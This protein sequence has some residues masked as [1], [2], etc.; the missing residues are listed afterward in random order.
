MKNIATALTCLAM[1]GSASAAS[2]AI[3]FAENTNQAFV[4]GTALGPTGIDGSNWNSS[5]DRD[6]GDFNAGSITNL[7]DD[8]GALTGASVTWNSQNTWVA[9]GGTGSDDAKL[10]TG[11]LDDA[12]TI[13]FDNTT[14]GAV[15][16]DITVSGITFD[17]YTIYGILASDAGDQY[18][19]RNFQVNG[20]YVWGGSN[21]NAQAEAYGNSTAAFNATGS[22]WVEIEQGVT[23]GNYWT[24]DATGS[25]V[26]VN[27][28]DAWDGGRGSLA[29]IVI[30]DTTAVP[31]P[32]S[33]ALLG[34]GGL[35]MI[36]RRRK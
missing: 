31:E 18:S 22:Y 5:I 19:S 3:N 8:S 35:A 2:I 14:G 20:S 27:G 7:K 36:L 17:T 29:G 23:R 30:V 21:R 33:A 25:T 34:L 16:V 4:G 32:S 12:N 10:T 15:G 1:I 11:Y 9:S 28:I 6:S 13:G 24:F 26:R